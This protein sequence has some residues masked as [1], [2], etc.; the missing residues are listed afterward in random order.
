MPTGRS[1]SHRWDRYGAAAIAGA[2]LLLI[3]GAA[4][5]IAR[6]QPV[7]NGPWCV[8]MGDLGSGYFECQYASYAECHARAWGVTMSGYCFRNPWFVPSYQ[9][10]YRER[11]G[12]RRY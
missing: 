11:R 6:A 3:L 12:S 2:G 9:K 4:T 1:G 7:G 8:D 5:D 10:P